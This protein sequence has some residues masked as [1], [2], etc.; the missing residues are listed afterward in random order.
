MLKLCGNPLFKAPTHTGKKT[1]DLGP[2]EFL[3]KQTNKD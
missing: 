3:I 1:R 2:Q